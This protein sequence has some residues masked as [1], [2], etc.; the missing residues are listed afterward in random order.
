MMKR[1]AILYARASD[2]KQ[3]QKDLS[4]PG[5][6]EALRKYAHAHGY[7]IVGEY[8][9]GG[10]S[11]RTT[12]H[13]TA[14]AE[15]ISLAREGRHTF[16]AILVWKFSRFSRNR[17][18]SIVL[19]SLLR[20]RGVDVVSINEPIDDSPAG[21]LQEGIIEVIDEFYSLNLAEDTLRGMRM[22]AEAGYY[23]GGGTP[24]GYRAA[25][26]SVGTA[27]RTRLVPDDEYAPVVKRV[28][29]MCAEG[30]G[31]KEIANSL[32][33]DGL[34]TPRGKRWSKTTILHILRN[35]VY[36][37]TIVWNRKP[38]SGTGS[39]D[40]SD[41]ECIRVE[42]SHPALVDAAVFRKVQS[43]IQERGKT[44]RHPREV[45][46]EYLL[47]GRVVCG[48]CGQKMI[49]SAAKSGRYRYY[50]CQNFAKRGKTACDAKSIS[51]E[52]LEAQ[53]VEHISEQVLTRNNLRRLTTLVNAEMNES[54][55]AIG[56]E[57][58][59]IGGNLQD[60][61]K[62]L[63]SLYDALE[64][65]KLSLDDL[66]PRIKE[67]RADIALLESKRDELT[68]LSSVSSPTAVENSVI[69]SM[70][71]DLN[72]LLKTGSIADQKTFLRSFIKGVTVTDKKV[73]IAYLMPQRPACKPRG[74]RVLSIDKIGSPG[75]TI[76][77]LF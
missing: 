32:N 42:N 4:I 56:D 47:S 76:L 27:E 49:G 10:K 26:V 51:K 44:H 54:Q 9:D 21:K 3:M 53:I 34:R 41:D 36:L 28:F 59:V 55:A 72:A 39:R 66:A 35:E 74:P 17:E 71:A 6:L 1:R 69:E 15:V 22:N 46:S 19:K 77:E 60:R 48:K 70:V 61:E 11:G 14:F 23:N 73:D 12:D 45:S 62:R 5:Q 8:S 57:L 52:R 16:V 68:S 63:R 43:L 37:G 64:T 75:W 65:T 20:R 58:A 24:T 30:T 25:R 40:N 7:E 13:R 33:A 2:A 18:D 31:A 38:N 50:T 67:L 29:Q